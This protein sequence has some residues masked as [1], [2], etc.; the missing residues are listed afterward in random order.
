MS[1]PQKNWQTAK[2][3][4]ESTTRLVYTGGAEMG[5]LHLGRRREDAITLADRTP[6]PAEPPEKSIPYLLESGRDWVDQIEL[7]RRAR[8]MGKRLREGKSPI[9][10]SPLDLR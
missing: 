7:A 3:V 1:L 10:N 9:A 4:L 2:I 6:G 8:E 5:K